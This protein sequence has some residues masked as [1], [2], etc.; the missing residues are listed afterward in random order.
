MQNLSV[1]VVRLWLVQRALVFRWRWP[2]DTARSEDAREPTY[3]ANCRVACESLALVW[4]QRPRLTLPLQSVTRG[5][6][7]RLVRLELSKPEQTQQVSV[8]IRYTQELQVFV[9]L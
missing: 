7:R 2:V 4:R 8:K 9:I 3:A 1:P 5:N 6:V